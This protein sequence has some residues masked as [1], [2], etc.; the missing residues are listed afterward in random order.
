MTS[1][2]GNDNSPCLLPDGRIVS[3]WLNRDGNRDGVHEIKAMTG[4]GRLHTMIVT[5]ADV[6]DAGL[7]CGP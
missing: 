1:Q 6:A 3:L 2:F 4:D 7:G 5:G